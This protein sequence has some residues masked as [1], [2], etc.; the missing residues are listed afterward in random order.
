M[1]LRGAAGSA[2]LFLGDVHGGA[3]A[4]EP[5]W[6]TLCYEV[7]S[8]ASRWLLGRTWG[9]GAAPAAAVRAAPRPGTRAAPLRRSS[10]G[11][12][13][14]RPAPPAR[15]PPSPAPATSAPP[16]PPCPPP[17]PPPPRAT[18]TPPPPRPPPRQSPGRRAA[19]RRRRVP[20]AWRH[21]RAR[22]REGPPRA[23]RR[24]Q[25]WRAL[26]SWRPWRP[27][28]CTTH[29]ATNSRCGA[30]WMSGPGRSGGVGGHTPVACARRMQ[31]V[32]MRR[33]R[34]RRGG[35]RLARPRTQAAWPPLTLPRCRR[36][37]CATSPR[38]PPRRRRRCPRR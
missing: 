21:P 36:T 4:F 19:A 26:A 24:C 37:C 29:T 22:L 14:R 35:A 34:E 9:G 30:S 13:K 28:S 20:R 8:P 5:L 7:R 15:P 27:T 18:L 12:R 3:R 38:P 6:R 16:A 33:G 10:W 23:W 11:R 31:P 32:P 2:Q 25:W 17:P 1:W